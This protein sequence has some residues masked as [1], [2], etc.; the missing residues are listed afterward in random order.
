VVRDAPSNASPARTALPT[1]HFERNNV[2][3]ICE[4]VRYK[5]MVAAS[6]SFRGLL[7]L[8]LGDYGCY[9][10]QRLSFPEIH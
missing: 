10:L 9:V 6:L 2:I 5:C 7:H 3:I 8:I 1:A 4:T